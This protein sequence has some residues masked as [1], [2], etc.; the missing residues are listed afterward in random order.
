MCIARWERRS[1]QKAMRKSHAQRRQRWYSPPRQTVCGKHGF[2]K[3]ACTG[4]PGMGNL[5]S[6]NAKAYCIEKCQPRF[7]FFK[8]SNDILVIVLPDDDDG[9]LSE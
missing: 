1:V 6:I 5:V 2:Q 3:A 8:K 4:Y 7:W 9:S